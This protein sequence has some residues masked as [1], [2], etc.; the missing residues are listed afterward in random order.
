[1]EITLSWMA[2]NWREREEICAQ[3]Q[4]CVNDKCQKCGCYVQAK[5]KIKCAN[6]PAKLWGT[7][8]VVK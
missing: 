2:K 6:C 8:C 5:C 1:M 7:G 4:F 3:C